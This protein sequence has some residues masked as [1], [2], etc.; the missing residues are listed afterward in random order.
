MKKKVSYL[1]LFLLF[2]VFSFLTVGYAVYTKNLG[3]HGS[4]RL[5]SQGDVYIANV[6][7]SDSS[8]LTNAT[9]PEFTDTRLLMILF[10]IMNLDLVNLHLISVLVKQV[11]QL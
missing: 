3:I 10:M 6:I 8:N 4:V 9:N 2:L 1:I 11:M 7:L 5:K